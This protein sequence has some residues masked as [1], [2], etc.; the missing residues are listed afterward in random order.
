M[1]FKAWLDSDCVGETDDLRSRR[2]C[3]IDADECSTHC[4]QGTKV[5]IAR[6][7]GDA[8]F[9]AGCG[10]PKSSDGFDSS[11]WN[12]TARSTIRAK[13]ITYFMAVVLHV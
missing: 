1:D 13:M 12:L 7:S 10:D 5:L 4:T 2:S 9:C 8:E 3:K 6:L 11:A